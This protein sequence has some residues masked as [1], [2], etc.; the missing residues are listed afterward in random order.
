MRLL[1]E[2][3]EEVREAFTEGVALGLSLTIKDIAM[4]PWEGRDSQGLESMEQTMGTSI[5]L[6]ASNMGQA[7]GEEMKRVGDKL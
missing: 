6:C 5:L 3:E 4:W 2:V 1:P 7:V